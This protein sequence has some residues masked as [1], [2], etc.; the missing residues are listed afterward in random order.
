MEYNRIAFSGAEAIPRGALV[1]ANR[2]G[3]LH[4]PKILCHI[5]NF[6][7]NYNFRIIYIRLVYMLY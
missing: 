1:S 2:D 7:S 4:S 6:L 5:T 3:S